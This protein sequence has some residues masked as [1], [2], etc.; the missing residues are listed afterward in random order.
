MTHAAVYGS[1]AKLVD[2]IQEPI[3][4]RTPWSADAIRSAFGALF[5]Y[6]SARRLVRALRAG[7]RG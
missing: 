3:A 4:R 7:L 6:W 1:R 2:K 5:L